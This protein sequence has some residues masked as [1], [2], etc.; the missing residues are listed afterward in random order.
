MSILNEDYIHFYSNWFGSEDKA[1]TFLEKC[2][3][4]GNL[5]SRRLANKL[6]RVIIFSDFCMNNK[7][8]N[9]SIQ[10]FLWMALIESTEYIH[11]PEK[12]SEKV[13]KLGVILRFFRK[14]VTQDDKE[15]LLRNLRRSVLDDR[16]ETQTEISIDI[17]ARILYSIRNEFV[18][19]M[20]FHTS[21]FSES[22]D[23]NY[24]ETIKLREFKKDDKEER[25][26]E[27]SIT[28]Q[29]LRAIIIRSFINMIESEMR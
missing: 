7:K 20:D 6:A 1:K 5:V 16:F 28:H 19:G 15:E 27:M 10:I 22:N 12:D 29:Q 18:H 24:L 11:F 23:D 9:R 26:Y 3:E 4:E 14:Y 17:I 13:D 21:L 2:Y 8:G 25:H